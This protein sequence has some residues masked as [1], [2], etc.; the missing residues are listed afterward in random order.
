MLPFPKARVRRPNDPNMLTL[1]QLIAANEAR[2]A[3]CQV[4]PAR[5]GLVS[6]VASRLVAQSAK[7]SYTAIESTTDVPWWIVAV[8]HEREAGQD[9]TRSIAQG[10]PWRG[11]SV[12]VPKGRG[13]FASFYA[14]AVDALTK[15]PPHASQWK[16]WSAG[17]ALTLLEEYNGLGYEDYHAEASPYNWGATNQEEWGKYI[18]DGHWAHVWDMQI[19]CA[20][21]LKRMMELD[22][23]IHVQAAR[24]HL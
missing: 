20:A 11:I 15:C 16:D 23:T 14:A 24:I 6:Q 10:D 18:N 12:H 3:L 4:I 7:F 5:L 9:F 21:M 8:I 19:G 22:D 13:P 17:G 1:P 2:W